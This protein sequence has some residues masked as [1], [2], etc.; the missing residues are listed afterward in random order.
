MIRIFIGYDPRE[1]IAYHVL[2]YSILARASE[3]VSIAPLSLRGLRRVFDRERDPLQST[4]FAFTRFLVPALCAHAGWAL[5]LDCDMLM[6]DNVA[7]LWDLRDERYAVQV[8]K[9]A[10]EPSEDTKFLGARQ[11][12]YAR[13]NW[14]S[15]MLFNNARCRQLS[16]AYVHKAS[17]LDLH[18]FAWCEDDK[19]GALPSRWNHLAGYDALR[20]DAAIVHY[21][22]GGPWFD[23]YKTCD[24]AHEWR[25]ERDALNAIGK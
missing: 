20:S 1:A 6:L 18:Q 9:H 3:P 22:S 4:D 10:H 7:K 25:A 15:V 24:Y 14:S 5:F 13:K 19:I 23:A 2:S 11:T 21:T 8:V 12:R 17:G 16:A